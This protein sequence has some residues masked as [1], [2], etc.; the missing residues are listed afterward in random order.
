MRPLSVGFSLL[1]ALNRPLAPHLPPLLASDLGGIGHVRAAHPPPISAWQGCLFRAGSRITRTRDYFQK[2]RQ[3]SDHFGVA[4]Q[5]GSINDI[6]G[7]A[8]WTV[9][10]KRDTNGQRHR[11]FNIG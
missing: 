6:K 11:R 8:A 10:R 2:R 9:L 5:R 7:F 3:S 1:L 4:Q